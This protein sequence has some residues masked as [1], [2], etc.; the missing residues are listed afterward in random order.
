MRHLSEVLEDTI[1]HIDKA[2]QR[3]DRLTGVPTGYRELDRLLMGFQ[4]G[5]LIVVSAEPSMGKTTFALN[6]ALNAAQARPP[7]KVI[8]CFLEVDAREAVY[9]IL[10][11]N[12]NIDVNRFRRSFIATTETKKIRKAQED[13]KQIPIY[14]EDSQ[15]LTIQ[16]LRVEAWRLKA[17]VGLDMVII[18]YLH[19]MEG[20]ISF[21]KGRAQDDENIRLLKA[22][23]EELN[24]PTIVLTQLSISPDN[25]PAEYK[26]PFLSDLRERCSAE[27]HADVVMFLYRAEYYEKNETNKE[28]RGVMKVII[29]KQKGGPTGVVRLGFNQD[30]FRM[31]DIVPF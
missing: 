13:Y 28:E 19:L 11:I 1:H 30:T 25:R 14:I 10:S 23:A 27:K 15:M 29:A 26:R 4:P 6:L 2:N 3:G 21:T 8:Y 12:E 24:I 5:K 31:V 7:S 17:T 22:F 9:R 16:D 20:P 18:D